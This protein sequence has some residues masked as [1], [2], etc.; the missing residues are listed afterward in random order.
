[1]ERRLKGRSDGSAPAIGHILD[2]P[3]GARYVS[4]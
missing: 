2:V 4:K 1:M 3:K